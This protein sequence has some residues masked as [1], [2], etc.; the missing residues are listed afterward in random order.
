MF[1]QKYSPSDANSVSYVAVVSNI[2]QRNI[3]EG[4]RIKQVSK[5]Q[6]IIKMAFLI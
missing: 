1:K 2:V 6:T 5:I 4:G 3:A